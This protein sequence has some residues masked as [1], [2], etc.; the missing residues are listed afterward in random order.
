MLKKLVIISCCILLVACGK[1]K[2]EKDAYQ[3]IHETVLKDWGN[4]VP[5]DELITAAQECKKYPDI[6]ECTKLDHQLYDIAVSFSTCKQSPRSTLCNAVIKKISDHPIKNILPEA[7]VLPMPDHP[8]YFNLPTGFLE[9]YSSRAGYRYE[10]FNWW[11]HKYQSLLYK[12]IFG[13]MT[14]L[15]LWLFFI[16][17][18]SEKAKQEKIERKK[19]ADA[20]QAAEQ[21]AQDDK[22][23]EQEAAAAETQ[24]AEQEII[25]EQQN[26]QR[27]IQR[28][29]EEAHLAEEKQKAADAAEAEACEAANK[30][31]IEEMMKAAVKNL[32]KKK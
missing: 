23:K 8:F 3:H 5:L 31:Q 25:A 32:P 2:E 15:A 6:T 30:Q 24:Q 26:Q 7:E 17:Y 9:A 12:I 28:A 13:T 21:K 18:R 19:I 29:R 22:L 14:A 20:Q 10:M 1:G 27:E 4:Y 11:I 16:F